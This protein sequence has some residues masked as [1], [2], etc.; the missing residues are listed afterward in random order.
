M[1]RE[2]GTGLGSISYYR[3]FLVRLI[4]HPYSPFLLKLKGR[5]NVRNFFTSESSSVSGFCREIEP[6]GASYLAI[7]LSYKE[8]TNAVMEA[9]KSQDLIRSANGANSNPSPKVCPKLK[10]IRWR[11]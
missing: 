2:R 10:T 9:E 6:I 5:K 1:K 7:Y 11:E 8:L 3:N 4:A